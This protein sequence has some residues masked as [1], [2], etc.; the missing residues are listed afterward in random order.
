MSAERRYNER[1]FKIDESTTF[2]DGKRTVFVETM[3]PGTAV[4]PHFHTRFTETFDLIS[5]SMQVFSTDAPDGTDIEQ[6]AQS[7]EVGKQVA[8]PPQRYHM[9][10]AGNE[11]TVL[12][13]ILTPGDAD[14]ER[15][16]MMLDGMARDGSITGLADDMDL[17]AIVFNLSD[18]H[19][20]GPLK[21]VLDDLWATKGEVLM[22]RKEELMMKYD[23]K[24][25]LQRL[26]S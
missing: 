2:N 1:G 7:L 16:L 22:N 19:V 3:T 5:G 8:I 11:P 6:C 9:Y 24:E 23:T 17:T 10:K 13:V 4:P 21:K 12:R 18:A 20:A 26:M 15:L 25:A 14:F